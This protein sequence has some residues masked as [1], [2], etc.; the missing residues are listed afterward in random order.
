MIKIV[1]GSASDLD[2]VMNVMADAFDPAFGEAWTR[3]QLWASLAMPGTRIVLANTE[4]ATIGFALTRTIIDETELLMIG[5]HR[6][7]QR[8]AVAS[9]LLQE[10]LRLGTTQGQRRIFLEVRSGNIAQQFYEKIGFSEI[11]RRSNYYRGIDNICYDA[12][13]MGIDFSEK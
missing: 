2:A 13:T 9:Q 11:G 1:E 5:V 10:I 8:K 4:V 12:I 6:Q 7:W 3:N